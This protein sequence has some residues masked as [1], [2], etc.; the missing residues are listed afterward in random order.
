MARVSRVSRRSVLKLAVSGAA[1]LGTDACSLSAQH[2]AKPQTTSSGAV[3]LVWQPWRSEWQQG[4]EELFYQKT[5]PF[6]SQNPGVDITVSAP[7]AQSNIGYVAAQIAA[8]IGPDVFSGFGFPPAPFISDGLML[9]LTD[10]IQ[11]N[12]INLDIFDAA[13]LEAY[14]SNNGHIFCLPAVLTTS[15]LAINKAVLDD[16]GLTYPMP[17][18][19]YQSAEALWKSVTHTNAAQQRFGVTFD[20]VGG[21]LPGPE[22]WRG[23]GAWIVDPSDNAQCGLS[24]QSAM[25]FADWYWPLFYAGVIANGTQAASI[26]TS[27][28]VG[29][30]V[31]FQSM[32]SAILLQLALAVGGL[33]FSFLPYPAWPNGITGYGSLDFYA[34][35]SQTR[36]PKEAFAFLQWLTCEPEWP[37]AMVSLQLALPALR[38]LWAEW[39]DMVEAVAPVFKGKNLG[40]FVTAA[41]QNHAYPLIGWRYSSDQAYMAL[42][43]ACSQINSQQLQPRPGLVS[44]VQQVEAIEQAG[45]KAVASSTTA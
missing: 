4:W 38:S 27:Q 26:K 33:K 42:I 8:G 21:T 31:V 6:R 28:L 18:W 11:S 12:N 14:K 2:T 7:T 44:A 39:T 5:E 37:K 19:T 9:D 13:Q 43:Q 30:Q 40:A 3:T 16:L 41:E 45:A 10:Y 24:S 35:N 25:S 17:G 1:L 23:W 15:A 20:L 36:H 29:G 22:Y 32:G 34:I